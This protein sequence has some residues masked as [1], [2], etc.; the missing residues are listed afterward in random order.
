MKKMLVFFVFAMIVFSSCGQSP[1]GNLRISMK[2]APS[3]AESI[4]VAIS[5]LSAHATGG[6]WVTVSGET[7]TVD[8]IKLLNGQERLADVTLEEGTYTEIRLLTTSGRIVIDG[9]TYDLVIP[10]SEVKIPARFDV[11]R[12]GMT[13]LLLDFDADKSIEVHPT[14]NGKNEYHLRPVITLVSVTM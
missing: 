6:G 4:L 1:N 12:S 13:E 2:D 11:L 8:L 5:G 3:D 14:G 10:S 7:K 9:Q